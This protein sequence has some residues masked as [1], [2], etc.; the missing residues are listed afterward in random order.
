MSSGHTLSRTDESSLLRDAGRGLYYLASVATLGLP[1][2]VRYHGSLRALEP[3]PRETDTMLGLGQEYA[4]IGH[5][6]KLA[7][8]KFVIGVQSVLTG[9]AWYE[10]IKA[11]S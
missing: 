7:S 5:R 2:T 3:M 11:L 10:I 1:Q 4:T 9:F 6:A 8:T